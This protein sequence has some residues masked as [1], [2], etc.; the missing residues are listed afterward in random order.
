MKKCLFCGADIADNAAFCG[1]CGKSQVVAD[2]AVAAQSPPEQP[3]A[4]AYAPPQVPPAGYPAQGYGAQPV[5]PQQYP[6]SGYPAQEYGAQQTP[7][8][9]YPPAGGYYAP[10][11]GAPGFAPPPKEPSKLALAGKNYFPWL[12]KGIFGTKEPM[13]PLFAAIVPF[14]IVFFFTLGTAS[15]MGWH[16][17]AF[18]LTWFFNL[19]YVAVL[20]VAVWLIKKLWDKDNTV[21][22]FSIFAEYSSYHNIV[23]PIILL[24][25]ILGIA[26]PVFHFSAHII[27]VMF[28]FVRL[29]SLGAALACLFSSRDGDSKL[30]LK[31]IAVIFVFTAMWY[32]VGACYTAGFN[33][34]YYNLFGF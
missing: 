30:W 27:A 11:Q 34:S 1:H 5:P 32:I 4:P 26:V 23:L 20:P 28:Q 8:Q 24:T 10:P 6:P 7:P 18:F 16:A 15:Q 17:G 19:V 31:I 14:A 13:H 12:Q 29:L 25:M 22:P 21:T 9:Q 33:W 3:Q 2:A